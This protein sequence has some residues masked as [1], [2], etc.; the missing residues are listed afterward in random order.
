MFVD[1]A[2]F[3]FAPD[4]K[5]KKNYLAVVIET[6]LDSAFV[7]VLEKT[8]FITIGDPSL[9]VGKQRDTSHYAFQ[10]EEI[11]NTLLPGVTVTTKFKNKVEQF[12]AEYS[13]GLFQNEDAIVAASD[14][15]ALLHRAAGVHA[16]RVGDS[17]RCIERAAVDDD[18]QAAAF[19]NDR[20]LDRAT[21]KRNGIAARAGIDAIRIVPV[22][23]D[24]VVPRRTGV[25]AALRGHREDE[26]N[27]ADCNEHGNR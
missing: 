13:H 8:Q 11:D 9:L 6:P 20:I 25:R 3:V 21:G 16:H 14:V 19:A 27:R 10:P 22:T 4:N 18:Q 26:R 7:P 23:G 5:V 15:A 17:G 24:A 2:F 12:N 1:S